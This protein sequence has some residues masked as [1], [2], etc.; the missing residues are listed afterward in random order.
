MGLEVAIILGLVSLFGTLVGVATNS[1][2]NQFIEEMNKENQ[3]FQQQTNAQNH[4]WSLEAAEWE[5]QHNKPQRQYADLLSAGLTPAAAAQKI[6]GANVSYSPATAVAPQNMPKSSNMLNDSL[7]QVIGEIGDYSSMAQ[8]QASAE[9]VK[10]ETK[11]ITETSVKK[12]NAEIEKILSDTL[13]SYSQTNVADSQAK[14][15]EANTGLATANTD[16]AIANTGLA[17]ANT[18]LTNEKVVTEKVNQRAIELS[19]EEKEIQ[20]D[21]TR[22]T[23]EMSV[24]KTEAEI[25]LLS[26]QTAKLL[27]ETESLEFENAYKKWR[28]TYI[29]TYGVAPEQGWEDTLFKAV[30]DGKAKPMLDSFSESLLLIFDP[31]NSKGVIESHFEKRFPRFWKFYESNQGFREEFNKGF[32]PRFFGF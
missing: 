15:N 3:A 10:A 1:E 29:E 32:F 8:A 13:L 16:L 25:K 31:E 11:V 17:T 5:Y 20:L 27:E 2:N 14:L 21:F 19:N 23:L 18:D 7:M 24:Q 9:K 12:A 4:A 26:E 28:N 30:V 6:S 22:K